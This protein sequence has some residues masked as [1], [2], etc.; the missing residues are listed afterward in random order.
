M[1]DWEI[2][3]TLRQTPEFGIK[4][5]MEQ[6]GKLVYAVARNRLP[7]DVF[8]AADVEDC[9]A[10]TFHDFYFGLDHYDL[11]K[12]SLR[13]W[14]CAIARNKALEL[15]RQRCR[16]GGVFPLDEELT[17]DAILLESS[18]EE[19]A[20]RTAVLTAVKELEEPE[21]EILLR[22][23]YLGEPSKEIAARL[24]L[25]VANVDTRTHRAVEKLRNKLKEW[26]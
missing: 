7:A 24:R 4:A 19:Q 22:K 1:Q 5:L 25:T 17:A 12:G 3:D 14:L 21:R 6:Y 11:E 13:A 20:L 8:C 10:D 9:V 2:L 18:L 23:F 15:V 26:R 16:K